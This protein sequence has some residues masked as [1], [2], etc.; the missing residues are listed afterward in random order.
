MQSDGIDIESE[1][2]S[3]RRATPSDKYY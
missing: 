1:I 3:L 2:T